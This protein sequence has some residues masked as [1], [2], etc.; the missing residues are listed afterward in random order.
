MASNG[1]IAELESVNWLARE[2]LRGR[3]MADDTEDEIKENGDQ[4]PYIMIVQ[5][6]N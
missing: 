1:W 6:T 5:W 4:L 2:W 3:V